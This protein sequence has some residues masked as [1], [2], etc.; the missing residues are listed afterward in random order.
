MRKLIFFLG[1]AGAGKT[2]LAKALAK[3]HPAAVLDMDS[4]SRP[5][6]EALMKLAGLDPNDRDSP[7]YKA[8]CRD[9]GYRLTMNA[10]LDNLEIGTDAIVIGPFTKEVEDP[11]WLDRELARIGASTRD[12]DVKVVFVYLRYENDYRRRIEG[13]D[14][15]L[16]RWK[17]ENWEKFKTSLA[18]REVKWRLPA[19]SVVEFDNSEPLTDDTVLR[20]AGLVYGE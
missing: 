16:D 11:A 13:R 17:L 15:V 7:E 19:G 14:S 10:A 3:R 2:T 18:K 9:L 8:L 4:L 6:S 1:G 5:A 20:L 12:V